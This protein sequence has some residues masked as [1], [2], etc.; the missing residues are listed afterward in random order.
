MA[1][2]AARL[3]MI[4]AAALCS[5]VACA[6]AAGAAAGAAP[7]LP[8]VPATS[9]ASRTAASSLVAT[10]LAAGTALRG[11]DGC[12]R[13]LRR[14]DKR[15][16]QVN[17]FHVLAIERITFDVD[18]SQA[19]ADEVAFLDRAIAQMNLV[20]RRVLDRRRFDRVCCQSNPGDHLPR[21]GDRSQCATVGI[22]D[23]DESFVRV[24]ASQNQN[25]MTLRVEAR[26]CRMDLSQ[27]SER[28]QLHRGCEC[29]GWRS[30]VDLRAF[31]FR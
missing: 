23:F 17:P 27:K 14:R 28:A 13:R 5:F 3:R 25:I 20:F 1:A 21:V 8:F 16:G 15:T 4:S 31:H 12:R 22:A 29:H 30:L 11:R 19:Q 18:F 7:L 26:R 6:S 9:A 2:L 24:A 10:A